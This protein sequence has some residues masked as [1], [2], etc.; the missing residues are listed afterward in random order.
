[1]VSFS[2]T[3]NIIVFVIIFKYYIDCFVFYI[4]SSKYGCICHTVRRLVMSL[5]TAHTMTFGFVFSLISN[6]YVAIFFL[7]IFLFA[8]FNTT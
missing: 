6:N 4:C 3:Q 2:Y 7:N 8:F 1:M 5:S